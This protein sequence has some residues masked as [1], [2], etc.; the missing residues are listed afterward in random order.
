[1]E[2]TG[3]LHAPAI[4]SW[5]ENPQY[6]LNCGCVG[7]RVDLDIMAKRRLSCPAGM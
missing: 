6:P 1:M 4:L 7:P 3:H 5:G 2:I